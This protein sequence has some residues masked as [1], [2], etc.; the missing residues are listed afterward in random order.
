MNQSIRILLLDDGELSPVVRIL[1]NLDLAHTRRRGEQVTE[2][3]SPPS[4]LLITTPRCASLVRRGSPRDAPKGRPIRIIGA[5]DHSDSMR[6]KLQRMGFDLLVGL[7]NSEEVWGPLI[8]SATYGGEERREIPRTVIGAPLTLFSS[9]AGRSDPQPGLLMD[10]SSRSCRIHLSRPLEVGFH[11]RLTLDECLDSDHPLILWGR[12]S[13]TYRE[14]NSEC[15]GAIL[16]F[17]SD[18]DSDLRVDLLATLQRWSWGPP[19]N[20]ECELLS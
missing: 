6:R 16:R 8:R 18:M 19:P 2:K 5:S 9:D 7:P 10:V 4:E 12:V 1:E 11:Y 17:D 3:L 20:R 14:Q 15:C 13:R